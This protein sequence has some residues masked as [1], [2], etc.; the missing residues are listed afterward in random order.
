MADLYAPTFQTLSENAEL[1]FAGQELVRFERLPVLEVL[2]SSRE[3]AKE[4]TVVASVYSRLLEELG[5][6]TLFKYEQI[7]ESTNKW[8]T[9]LVAG[10]YQEIRRNL[11]LLTGKVLGKG[12]LSGDE[13]AAVLKAS[14]GLESIRTTMADV[15]EAARHKRPFQVAV[16]PVISRQLRLLST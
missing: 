3:F 4:V 16:L 2:W 1:V 15:E 9:E 8:E 5:V 14:P 10:S 7:L 12:A 11:S 13:V 6:N